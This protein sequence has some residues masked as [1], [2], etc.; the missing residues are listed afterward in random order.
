MSRILPEHPSLEYLKKQAKELLH[1]VRSGAPDALERFRAVGSHADQSH[2]RLSYAQRVLA[3]EYG[4]A[5]WARLK[6]HVE[7]ASKPLDPAGTVGGS[8]T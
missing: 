6:A 3:R 4:F 5:S 2:P 7:S 8:P 1:A